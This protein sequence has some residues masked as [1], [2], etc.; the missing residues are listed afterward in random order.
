MKQIL[1]PT[2]FS[3]CADK[4]IDFAVQSA[5]IVP[6]EIILLHS[7]EVKDNLYSDYMGINREFNVSMLNDAKEKLAQ[8]KKNIEETDGLVVDTFIS[9]NS[10]YDAITRSVKEK[11][12]DMVVM[13]TL[14]ASGIK[15]KLWGSRTAAI[16]GRSDIPVM[17]IPIEYEWKKPQNIL[18]ATNRFEKEPAILDYLFELAGLYMSRVQVAVFTDEG[19]DKA[20]TFLDHKRKISEYEEYLTDMYNEE[21]LTSA[22]LSGEDFETTLQNFIREND[23]DI[24]VMVTYQN[25]FWNRIFN[26]S[27]TKQMSYHTNVPLLAIPVNKRDIK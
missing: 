10:L 18:L 23:I 16:I 5:K 9:T 7:F 4:A 12:I 3:K 2:D 13:G 21:T 8:L 26:P 27:K 1:V 20:I 17:V 25:T 19:D 24:L 22:H 11:K 15:G 14:G 6:V